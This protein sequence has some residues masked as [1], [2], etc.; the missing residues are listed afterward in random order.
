M[1]L[2][3]SERDYQSV[4]NLVVGGTLREQMQNLLFP[5]S[6]QLSQWR[7]RVRK[8]GCACWRSD[9]LPVWRVA[10]KCS[11]QHLDIENKGRS[12][13]LLFQR[14]C[15]KLD[16]HENVHIGGIVNLVE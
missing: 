11:K 8:G 15:Q 13:T 12:K 1:F 3:G 14:C 10:C 16:T 4:G 9:V 2:D 7:D 6:E 5:W